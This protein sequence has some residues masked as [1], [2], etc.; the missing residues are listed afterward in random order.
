MDNGQR[1]IMVNNDRVNIE[2]ELPEEDWLFLEKV[3]KELNFET[4]DDLVNYIL[5]EELKKYDDT[6]QL[7][8]L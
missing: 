1:G 3:R 6:N 5:E 2:I 4:L 7:E 8:K